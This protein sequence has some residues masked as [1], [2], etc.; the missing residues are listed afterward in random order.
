MTNA[1]N[2]KVA[3]ITLGTAPSVGVVVIIQPIELR[4]GSASWLN[5]QVVPNIVG[6]RGMS[7]TSAT[8]VG[9]VTQAIL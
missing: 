8:T 9:A 7:C 2:G 4:L 5:P 1:G 3:L 6:I